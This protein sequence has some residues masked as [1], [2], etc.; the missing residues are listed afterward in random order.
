M[1]HLS[2]FVDPNHLPPEIIQRLR[3]PFNA[4]L[5]IVFTPIPRNCNKKPQFSTFKGPRPFNKPQRV[6]NPDQPDRTIF[7]ASTASA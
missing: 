4:A 6:S 1:D 7:K 5:Q 3:F 2:G